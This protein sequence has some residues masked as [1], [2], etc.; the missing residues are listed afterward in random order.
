MFGKKSVAQEIGSLIGAGTTVTGDISF[1]GGLR[2]DGIVRGAVCCGD[3]D[4][5]GILVI[6]EHGTIEGEVRASHIVV[7]GR[8]Q[9]PVHAAVLIELQ[10]KARVQGDVQYRALEMHHGA[11]VEGLMVHI[12][13]E[14]RAAPPK[15]TAVPPVAVLPARSDTIIA[16][17]L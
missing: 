9:G 6:S 12:P 15:L 2:V 8:I 1:S 17:Q 13:A 14:G 10:P 11:V 7:S 4:K 3:G 16:K 5:G